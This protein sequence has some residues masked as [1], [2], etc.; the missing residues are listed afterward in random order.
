MGGLVER[1][2]GQE[3]V[4]QRGQVVAG[5]IG[6]VALAQHPDRGGRRE[7]HGDAMTLD[8][9]PP[10]TGI[11]PDRRAFVQNG[12]HAGDQRGIDDVGMTHHPADV[13][14]G[15]DGLARMP[16]EDVLHRGGQRHGIAADIALHTLGL[17]GGARGV[18]DVRRR[19]R[20]QPCHRHVGVEVLLA[21]GLPVD[22]TT[23]DL[24]ELGVEA[25]VHE[26]HMG[27][28]DAREC[29]RFVEQRLVAHHLARAH[30]G[31]GA[32]DQLRRGVVD[33]GGE[34]V[35]REATEHHRMD[36]ADAGAG[37]HRHHR[38]RNH[39]HVEQHPLA[40]RNP[41]R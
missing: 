29:D 36:G 27:R 14:G 23:L 41:E 34:A 11:G 8:D 26:Q 21:Q 15:E 20:F 2:A 4:P 12:R 3:Q 30:A 32:D 9:A 38:L 10:D 7:H 1:L 37:E 24:R 33:A 25:A 28:L 16:A 31:V 6:L 39:R 5:D 40:A 17:T 22:V 18:E 13:G 35:R 19:V